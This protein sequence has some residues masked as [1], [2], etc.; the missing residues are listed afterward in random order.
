[1]LLT[2]WMPKFKNKKIPGTTFT[3]VLIKHSNLK[4]NLPKF[5][6]QLTEWKT[7]WSLFSSRMEREIHLSE[8]ERIT[9]LLEAMT[10]AEGKDVVQQVWV[11]VMMK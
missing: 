5:S 4:L 2:K 11:A 8:S 9:C 7:L 10:T 6:G 3:T 1:M